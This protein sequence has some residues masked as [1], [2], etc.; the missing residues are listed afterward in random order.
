M[1]R[2]GFFVALKGIR[3]RQTGRAGYTGGNF[4]ELTA[5][6]AVQQLI[7]DNTK[8]SARM[9]RKAQGSQEDSRDAEIS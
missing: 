5:L 6:K 4:Q 9:G 3:E 2:R 1:R 8:P 7:D